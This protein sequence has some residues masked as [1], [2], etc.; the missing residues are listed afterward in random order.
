VDEQNIDKHGD[1]DEL[2]MVTINIVLRKDRQSD[3][4]II[5][6]VLH[7]QCCRVNYLHHMLLVQS[8]HF[9]HPSVSQRLET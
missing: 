7:K 8:S 4:S 2:H 3:P 5:L 6:A 9:E 1:N